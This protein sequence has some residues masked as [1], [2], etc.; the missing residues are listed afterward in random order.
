MSVSAVFSPCKFRLCQ[1][2]E[3]EDIMILLRRRRASILLLFC[4]VAPDTLEL[5]VG[6][7]VNGI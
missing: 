1:Q 2:M 3:I 6:I 4:N 7:I 5:S